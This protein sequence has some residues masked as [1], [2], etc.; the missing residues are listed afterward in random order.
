MDRLK[1]LSFTD[2]L[3]IS[4]YALAAISLIGFR[5]YMSTGDN[6]HLFEPGYTVRSDS[7]SQTDDTKPAEPNPP[8]D[9]DQIAD[10]EVSG[11]Q[12]YTYVPEA[13]T[14]SAHVP[15][16]SAPINSSPNARQ[17]PKPEKPEHKPLPPKPPESPIVPPVD[18]PPSSEDEPSDGNIPLPDIPFIEDR[19]D[20]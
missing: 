10:Q 1:R 18:T 6:K 3:A 12:Q 2:K 20:S 13:Q 9:P 19:D 14:V 5:V 4:G 11:P 17:Y 15:S 8:K 16:H 7:I